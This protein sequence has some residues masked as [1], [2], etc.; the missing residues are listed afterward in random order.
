MHCIV[1]VQFI[2]IIRE[3]FR[4]ERSNGINNIVIEPVAKY[5]IVEAPMDA[6][7]LEEEQYIS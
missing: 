4:E 5:G 2:G 3:G 1:I 7:L 6:D